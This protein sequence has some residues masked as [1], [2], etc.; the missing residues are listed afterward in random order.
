MDEAH[1]SMEKAQKKYRNKDAKIQRSIEN[2]E[3]K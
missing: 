1:I 3:E 2:L